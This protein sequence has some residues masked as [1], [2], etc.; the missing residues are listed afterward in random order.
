MF[1]NQDSAHAESPRRVKVAGAV[2]HQDAALRRNTD[3]GAKHGEHRHG[4]L[5]PE[6]TCK[7][8]VLDCHHLS[9][10]S[11]QSRLA[12]HRLGI[13]PWCIAKNDLGSGQPAQHPCERMLRAD[14]GQ[15][16]AKRMG[17]P[18]EGMRIDRMVGNH[19]KQSGA[20]RF[21]VRNP[22]CAGA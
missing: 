20:V 8:H 7:T 4:G 1:Q 21:P 14:M 17:F 12:Q 16:F 19:A 5:G 6:S 2:F 9:Q 13:V 18:K 22:Q 3:T 10:K 15:K 11:A